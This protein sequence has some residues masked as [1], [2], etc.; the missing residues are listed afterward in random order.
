MATGTP[1]ALQGSLIMHLA[2]HKL[3]Q[4]FSKTESSTSAVIPF[5]YSPASSPCITGKKNLNKIQGC[6]LHSLKH[7]GEGITEIMQHSADALRRPLFQ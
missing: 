3:L 1:A 6:S 7:T 5:S 2:E 4:G